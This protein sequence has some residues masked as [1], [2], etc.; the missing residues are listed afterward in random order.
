MEHNGM[1][2]LVDGL[3]AIV[4]EAT[5]VPLGKGRCMVDRDH[6][7]DILDEL[8]AHIPGE[9]EE[10]RK[11]VAARQEYIAAAKR[12][13]ESI[14]RVAEEHAR[15]RMDEQELVRE[16]RRA[17]SDITQKAEFK[18][19]E[20]KKMA[21]VYAEETLKRT[22]EVIGTALEE[23]RASRA[24]F[25]SVATQQMREA[26]PPLTPEVDGYDENEEYPE[27]FPDYVDDYPDR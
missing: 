5:S 25:R 10:A 22:E 15:A 9:V 14:R 16:A 2:E 3:Y 13:A 8:K 7:L 11:L 27:E 17:A 19:S 26:T 1:L 23:V 24:K 4:S 20:L 18:A 21:N 6:V 12:E